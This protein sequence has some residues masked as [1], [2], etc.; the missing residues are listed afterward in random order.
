MSELPVHQHHAGCE[1]YQQPEHLT[2]QQQ[3]QIVHVHQAAPDRTV[4]RIALGSGMGAGAVA[5]AVFLGP[6]LIAAI[7]AITAQLAV[8]ALLVAVVA[9]AVVTVVRS[10]S[11]TG[12]RKD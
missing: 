4:Q 2:P 10:V 7:T 9:W 6:M 8:L 11:G 3:P 1:H 5:A 12:R